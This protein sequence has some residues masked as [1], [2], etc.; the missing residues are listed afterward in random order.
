MSNAK[1]ISAPSQRRTFTEADVVRGRQEL[2]RRI[3]VFGGEKVGKSSFA[4]GADAPVFIPLDQGAPHLDIDRL[5]KP[6]SFDELLEI[7]ALPETW[8]KPWK[9]LVID[10]I[11]WAEEMAWARLMHGVGAKPTES[12]RDE[13]EKVGGGFQKGFD[14][15]VGVWRLLQLALERQWKRGM[16]I[17]LLAHAQKVN[18]KD[19]IGVNYDRWEPAMHAKAA[20]VFKQWVDDVLFFRHEVLAKPEK[21]KTIAVATDERVIHT[22]WSKAWDAGNR[23][24][25]PPELPMA[26]GA[27]WEGVK[28]GGDRV[29]ALKTEIASLVK[30][31]GGDDV[32]KGAAKLVD[33]A[34]DNTE[35][36]GEIVTRLRAKLE[37]TA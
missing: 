9:T 26:W 23:A 11:N 10:P 37:K 30:Q 24:D 22:T 21:N 34:K 32:A 27:Y 1:Q 4:S 5:P 13:I 12:T 6:E 17:V 25:L 28:R 20:N 35:R 31:I 15:A 3:F 19:P 33:E 16:N 18:F 8:K 2:P 36:L 14:A 29:A 7:V